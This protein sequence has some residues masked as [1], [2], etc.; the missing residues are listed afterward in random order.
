MSGN[1]RLRD[2]SLNSH[3]ATSPFT[4][5]PELA[6]GFHAHFLHNIRH[7]HQI[8]NQSLAEEEVP[9]LHAK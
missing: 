7:T 1:K 8:I 9:V 2:M 5:T 6:K 3:P 4:S